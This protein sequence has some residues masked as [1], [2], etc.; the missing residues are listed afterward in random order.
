MSRP[1][2]NNELYQDVCECFSFSTDFPHE[3]AAE[4]RFAQLED[5]DLRNAI[6]AFETENENLYR[7]INRG[8]I[9][10]E[11]VLYHYGLEND[12]ENGQLVIPKSLRNSVLCMYRAGPLADHYGLDRTLARIDKLY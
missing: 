1:P 5:E 6:N 9:M 2:C 12:T 7:Y 8:Y 4:F 3:G 10:F 11:G